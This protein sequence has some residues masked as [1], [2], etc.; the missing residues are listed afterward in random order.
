MWKKIC[1][2]ILAF[3]Q[4]YGGA[5]FYPNPVCRPAPK[6]GLDGSTPSADLKSALHR[7]KE[8]ANEKGAEPASRKLQIK[9]DT[10]SPQVTTPLAPPLRPPPRPPPPPPLRPH[11][12][13]FPSTG[14]AVLPT[15]VLR[16]KSRTAGLH[17]S[18]ASRSPATRRPTSGQRWLHGTNA[19]QSNCLTGSAARP[20]PT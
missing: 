17:L 20:W 3:S 16:K 12:P 10:R 14:G 4:D 1:S 13:N 9:P 15:W 6:V 5:L 8:I 18:S 7:T 11:C 19:A 2:I